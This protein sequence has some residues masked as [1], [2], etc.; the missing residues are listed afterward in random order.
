MCPKT[1]VQ[2]LHISPGTQ[3]VLRR[4][5]KEQG[6]FDS[7]Y[8]RKEGVFILTLNPCLFQEFMHRISRQTRPQVILQTAPQNPPQVSPQLPQKGTESSPKSFT[9]PKVLEV[10]LSG[11][12]KPQ[13]PHATPFIGQ[14]APQKETLPT[15]SHITSQD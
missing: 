15:K 12:Q 7:K 10:V 2:I 3:S 11:I 1:T 8:S 13:Q 9:G 6:L 4:F 5:F 14:A